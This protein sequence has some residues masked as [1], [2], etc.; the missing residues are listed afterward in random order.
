MKH[1]ASEL[2]P[3]G[4]TVHPLYRGDACSVCRVSLP[5]HAVSRAVKHRS[6][7]EFWY[8]LHGLGIVWRK[9]G[10]EEE[11]VAV[12]TG[13]WLTIP[14]GSHFQFRNT[15]EETLSFLCITRPPW[16]GPEEAIRVEDHWT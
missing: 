12:S 11:E 5:A 2:A 8:F 1:T 3:D 7:E 13:T 15:S 4:S 9:N 10:D 6:V 16:P 14:T